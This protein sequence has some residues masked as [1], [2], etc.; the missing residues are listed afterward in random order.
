MST[1]YT[2][3]RAGFP[4]LANTKTLLGGVVQIG[5][6]RTPLRLT[7]SVSLSGPDK[8]AREWERRYAKTPRE[9]SHERMRLGSDSGWS[10]FEK[11]NFER[12]PPAWKYAWRGGRRS[13]FPKRR[14]SCLKL[15]L[16]NAKDPT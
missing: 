2:A 11:A 5:C 7:I 3:N 14:C 12:V 6:T 9:S 13:V 4:I 1:P 10:E 8:S 16:E 15:L